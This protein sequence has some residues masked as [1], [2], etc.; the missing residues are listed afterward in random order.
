MTTPVVMCDQYTPVM[1]GISALMFAVDVICFIY[2]DI[3]ILTPEE[4]TQM[5][6]PEG[7]NSGN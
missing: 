6:S 2:R 4:V 1:I 7:M 3:R 5:G